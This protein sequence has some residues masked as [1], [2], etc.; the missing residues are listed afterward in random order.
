[1]PNYAYKCDCGREKEQYAKAKDYE[2]PI[3][4]ECG[5]IMRRIITL[6]ST[7]IVENKRYSSVM[8]VNPSKIAESMRKYP[9]SVYTPD[10]RLVVNNRKDKLK[11]LRERG[12]VEYE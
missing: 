3:D 7:D 8:G 9:G 5:G 11:K 10:G 12:M 1:M 4:C 6:P 2:K